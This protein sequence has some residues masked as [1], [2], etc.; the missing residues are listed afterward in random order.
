LPT[1]CRASRRKASMTNI[2]Y[3]FGMSGQANC[4]WISLTSVFTQK[5]EEC[6]CWEISLSRFLRMV[7]PPRSILPGL[8]FTPSSSTPKNH[9]L[10]ILF[11]RTLLRWFS[12]APISSAVSPSPQK[13]SVSLFSSNTFAS[14]IW[15]ILL[16]SNVSVILLEQLNNKTGDK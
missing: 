4:S 16:S 15:T 9:T 2:M 11:R 3:R 5:L 8:I 1:G 13:T 10:L 14:A 7:G 12:K 6:L